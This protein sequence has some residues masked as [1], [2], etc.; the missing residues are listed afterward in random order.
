MWDIIWVLPQGH[1]SVSVSRHF[2]L[3]ALQCP[4]SVQKRFSRDHCCRGRSK[5]GCRIVGSHT[6]WELTT[7]AVHSSVTV[8][9]N[10]MFWKQI[11]RFCCKLAQ[12]I[13]KARAWIAQLWGSGGQRSSRRR[14]KLDLETWQRH[15]SRPLWIVQVSA[16]NLYFVICHSSGIM[17]EKKKGKRYK[18]V[19]NKY[20]IVLEEGYQQ[21]LN[22]L[23]VGYGKTGH[24]VMDKV[25][26]CHYL[27]LC[28]TC[29]SS[30][31]LERTSDLGV[32]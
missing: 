26:V 31:A 22:E 14:P 29:R 21:Y 15:Y 13:H 30:V 9:V 7:W 11:Y 12:V 28:M 19:K 10:T 2:L 6:R 18:P 17:W 4:C 3:Q 27:H 5:P 16:C 32:W 23:A 25:E 8:L 1:R 20:G 24:K